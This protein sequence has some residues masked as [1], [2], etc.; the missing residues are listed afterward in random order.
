MLI[1]G[2]GL[3][4]AAI[5]SFLIWRLIVRVGELRRRRNRKTRPKVT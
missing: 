1:V 5:A 2:S 4:A 3:A